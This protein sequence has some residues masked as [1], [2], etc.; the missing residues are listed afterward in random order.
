M[1]RRLFMAGASLALATTAR[2]H[3]PWEVACCSGQD[4]EFVDH[5]CIREI[6]NDI[7][8]DIP[9]G[10]HPMWPANKAEHFVAVTTRDK[11]RRAVGPEWGVCISA[12]GSLLCVYPPQGSV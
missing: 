7:H 2:A 3:G 1:H 4:C 12:S 6:G 9:P 10:G 11:L 8:I 5:R